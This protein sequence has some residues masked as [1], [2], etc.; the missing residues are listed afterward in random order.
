VNRIRKVSLIL[1]LILSVL[2]V[3]DYHSTSYILKHGGQELNPFMNWLM[4]LMGP[5]MAMAVTKVGLI[6]ILTFSVFLIKKR[7]NAKILILSLLFV[8][9]I[10]IILLYSSNFQF[11][12]M[13]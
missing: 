11:L 7:E 10:Y 5:E 6:L 8:N 1:L 3:F 2:N 4:S 13:L 9:L 12:R